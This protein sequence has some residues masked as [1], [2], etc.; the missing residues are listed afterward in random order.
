M[1]IDKVI[2]VKPVSADQEQ[3][4][5]A[6]AAFNE[7]SEQ[8]SGVYQKLQQQVVQLT[9][10]LALANG[11]LHRQLIAK[12]DLSQQL[13]FLLN[14]LPGGV[15]ALNVQECIEQIN[16]TALAIF[17]QPLL[18]LAW[19]QVIEE[20]LFPTTISNEWYLKT[21]ETRK[22][23]RIRVESSATGST[24]RRILLVND[25]TEAYAIQEQIRRNQ[26]LT[27]MGEMAANLA[28]Q[29]RTPLS[30]ALLYASHL[31]SDALTP[32][33]RQKFATKTIDR[34]HHLEHLTK[35]ML[36]FVKGETTQLENVVIS[37]LLTELQQVIEPQMISLNLQL[38]VRDHSQAEC[39]MTN[40]QALCGAM[41][42]LL[43]NAM[44]VSSPGDRII[45]TGGVEEDNIVLS[46]HDDGPG[47]DAV[48]QERMFEPFFT[49]RSEGTGLG[50][51]IV[52]G[53]IQSMGGSVQINSLP[54]S[55]SE[56]VIRLPKNKGDGR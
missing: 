54:D 42:N 13:S 31:G 40:H 19:H 37:D 51:A 53:V 15:L 9:R 45:L 1:Q 14:A 10:E 30:T 41:L 2:K 28:H 22:Q 4:K 12:E 18:G 8:L 11:E 26:R 27:S 32:D 16:P 38:I 34:L 6:F 7:A 3:L 52:R 29:I 55:G 39:L 23:R 50:L 24:G 44:Q 47:I 43:E 33:E 5:I 21:T 35:N 20:C 48:L 17:E 46:V 36:R 49:T 25:I 56:F